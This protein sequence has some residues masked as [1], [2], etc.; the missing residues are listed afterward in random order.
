MTK[1]RDRDPASNFSETLAPAEDA[2][3]PD[4]TGTPE[5][6]HTILTRPGTAQSLAA[7]D[8][9]DVDEG[10]SGE[11]DDDEQDE[12]DDEDDDEDEDE[13][14]DEDDEDEEEEED[15]DE[16]DAD[17]AEAMR[18]MT[19]PSTACTPVRSVSFRR[20]VA[21]HASSRGGHRDHPLTAGK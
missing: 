9:D 1:N 10:E 17:E 7:V 4:K 8:D 20:G 6:D 11:E 2:G 18:K 16:E 12:D 3:A 21:G 14:E 19:A 5:H 15:D 13:D